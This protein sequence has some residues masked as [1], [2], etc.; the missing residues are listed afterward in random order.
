[1]NK[2]FVIVMAITL[3]NLGSISYNYGDGGIIE[4]PARDSLASYHSNQVDLLWYSTDDN[5]YIWA[6]RY[7]FND[8]MPGLDSLKF[9]TEQVHVYIDTE[10]TDPELKL[11]ICESDLNQPGS[12]FFEE[13]TITAQSGW[14]SIEVPTFETDSLW[15]LIDF[16]TNSQN[17][18]LAGSWGDGTHSYYYEDNYYHNMSANGF[19][20]EFLVTLQGE[21]ILY[22]NDLELAEFS[23][24]DENGNGSFELA[25]DIYP[26]LTLINNSQIVMDSVYLNYNKNYPDTLISETHG[27]FQVAPGEVLFLDESDLE[28][29][30]F[31][32]LD[33][34]AQYVFELNIDCNDDDYES[35]NELSYEF[36]TFNLT[37]S[38][39]LVENFVRDNQ[40]TRDLWE[41][42]ENLIDQNDSFVINL[43]PVFDDSPFYNVNS[44]Q[45]F[46]YY[47]L[48][49]FP[50]TVIGGSEKVFGYIDG[51]YQTNFNQ[52]YEKYQEEMSA[53]IQIENIDYFQNVSNDEVNIELIITNPGSFVFENYIENCSFFMT[54]VEDSL[55]IRQD[56]FG[57]VLLKIFDEFSCEQMSYGGVDTLSTEFVLNE[58]LIPISNIDNCRF[59]YWCQNNESQQINFIEISPHLSDIEFESVANKKTELTNCGL[60]IEIFPNPFQLGNELNIQIKTQRQAE[61]IRISIFNIKGQLIRIINITEPD[62]TELYCWDGLDRHNKPVGSGIYLFKAEAFGYREYESLFRK[63]VLF[64]N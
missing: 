9:R 32:L 63:L 52:A 33:E 34:P 46:N 30:V 29:L 19:F 26:N 16:E 5:D 1:M 58:E 22:E 43:F 20:S 4:P 13:I 55:E 49:L 37:L 23:L 27:P 25:E 62:R 57:T 61:R 6:V 44:L 47:N 7:D 28:E 41:A 3:S 40:L 39:V 18:F 48:G 10:F 59:V 50:S 17:S 35:N 36:N 56:I 15:V 64:R 11:K 14:N 38:K 53:F 24:V 51:F 54:A 60:G 12:E 31:T 2:L 8:F 21:F 45:R 42:Q